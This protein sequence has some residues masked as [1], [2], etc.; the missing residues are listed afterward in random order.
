MN[1]KKIKKKRRTQIKNRTLTAQNLKVLEY[2]ITYEALKDQKIE[3]LPVEV[4]GRLEYLYD[5]I[6]H[7]PKKAI[8][9][10]ERW[11]NCK[12]EIAGGKGFLVPML[13]VG[14]PFRRFAS[15]CRPW[16]S[17]RPV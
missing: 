14:M 12:C 4:K 8:L 11:L 10:L 6:F 7:N 16:S 13:C 3:K 2:E 1:T 17:F 15:P 5:M 9:E